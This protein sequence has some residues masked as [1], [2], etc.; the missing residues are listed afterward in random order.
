MVITTPSTNLKLLH[1]QWSLLLLQQTSSSYIHNG[2]YYSLNK[3]QAP[4][5]T[6]VITTPSTNL[7]LLHTQY[8]GA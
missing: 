6:M 8:V 2:H 1:T 5:Y 4:T 3:P 7:K